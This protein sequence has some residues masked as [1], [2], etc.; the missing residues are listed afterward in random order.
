M[1]HEENSLQNKAID[2]RTQIESALNE[3]YKSNLPR[4]LV[5]L[6]PIFDIRLLNSLQSV[7]PICSILQKKFC[8]CA[9]LSDSEQNAMVDKIF[10]DYHQFLDEL[11]RSEKFNERDDFTVVL[12]PFLSKLK[13]PNRDDGTVDFTYFAPDCF[14]FSG[15]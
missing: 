15:K 3:L 1:F 4:T 7:S 8:P 14:H 11:T 6:I 5:N 10:H 9:S 2:Y 13:I 12:Q